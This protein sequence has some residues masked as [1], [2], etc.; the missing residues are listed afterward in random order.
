[1]VADGETQL[2][3][4]GA[5]VP[6]TA[7]PPN[8]CGMHYKRLSVVL[9]KTIPESVIAELKS[10]VGDGG[11]L[12][13]AVDLSAYL[14]EW[15]GLFTGC[16]PL[17]LRPV[18]TAE[19]ADILRCCNAHKVAVVPQGGNTGLAGGAIPGLGDQDE[20]L[21]SLERMRHVRAI[22][23]ANFTITV[24]A[25]CLLERLQQ[26]AADADCLFPLSMASEGSCQIGGNVSTNA[27]G[28]AVLRYGNTRDLVLGLEVV[29]PDGRVLNELKGVRKDNTGYD[30][31]QLF[32]GAE[33]SLGVVTAVTC[34]LFPKPASVATALIALESI[35]AVVE[36]FASART[37]LGDEILAF[38]TFPH[39]AMDMVQQH[40][41][42]CHSPFDDGYSW[43]V[44]LDLSSQRSQSM[45][46]TALLEFLEAQL[47]LGL[48]SDGVVAQSGAQRDAFWRIRHA[49]SEAQKLAGASIK[50]DISVPV[51]QIPLLIEK[52]SAVA[53]S[54]APGVRPVPFGHV[55]D[56]NIH[57]NLSQ[58]EAMPAK[59]FLALWDVMNHRI[60][61]LAVS[62]GGSFSAEHGI[63]L[64]KRE[65]LAR[66]ADPVGL[67]LMRSVKLAF[68]PNGIMNPNKL[69]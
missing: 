50:H 60:H 27:G 63:G 68:D 52:A 7:A 24:E 62:L 17:L 16:T 29:L 5:I 49:I 56:G 9:T 15:R 19:V 26:A 58:P 12:D 51:S 36:F 66:L 44:L 20:V 48:V 57:F 34:K 59:D 31:K 42:S 43:Y 11:W 28:T 67:Q 47:A 32:I 2:L 46:D 1:M 53:E 30:L 18:S 69:L 38:E 55:G 37:A 8:P 14:E 25:G 40:I 13:S 3:L 65:E 64:L 54:I 61:S 4:V 45:V 23:T 41:D 21:L 35:S 10:I 22:D 39:I 6:L 33:G